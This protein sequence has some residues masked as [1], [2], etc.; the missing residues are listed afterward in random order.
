MAAD[1]THQAS[2]PPVALYLDCDCCMEAG[3][4]KLKARFSGW[5]ELTV[6]LDIWHVMRRLAVGCTTDAHQ[7]YAY[8]RHVFLCAYLSGMQLMLRSVTLS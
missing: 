6:R 7:L 5:P 8:S 3:E 1:L 2:D 4:S